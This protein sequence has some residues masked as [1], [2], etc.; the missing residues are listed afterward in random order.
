ML[1]EHD[2]GGRGVWFGTLV[3]ALEKS[4]F[5]LKITKKSIGKR[6]QVI[7]GIEV[8]YFVVFNSSA[9]EWTMFLLYPHVPFQ[10]LFLHL[11]ARF[12]GATF[13]SL[14]QICCSLRFKMKFM[15]SKKQRQILFRQFFLLVLALCLCL[16]LLCLCTF[17]WKINFTHF[18]W[19]SLC[20]RKGCKFWGQQC[21]PNKNKLAS[22]HT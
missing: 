20:Y 2:N 14:K 10:F 11:F 5:S 16:C 3:L 1:N 15:Q 7:L 6:R 8:V 4:C 21:R 9:S 13:P 17:Q 18:M 12:A 22:T 19:I